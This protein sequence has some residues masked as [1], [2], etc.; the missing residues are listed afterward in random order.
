MTKKGVASHIE[1][2]L[3]T[4]V[5]IITL[6]ILLYYLNPIKDTGI[7]KDVIEGIDNSFKNEVY[8]NLTKIF[9]TS[10]NNNNN[11]KNNKKGKW[12]N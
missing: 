3:S 11:N 6:G 9:V 1:I 5:F 10:N 2:V 7:T 8:A 12:W 4:T